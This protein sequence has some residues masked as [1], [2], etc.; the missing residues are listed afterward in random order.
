MDIIESK[1]YKPL[2][3]KLKKK[4]PENICSIFFYNKGV[5]CILGDPEISSALPTFIEFPIHMVT[6]KLGL[7]LSTKIFNFKH[8]VN[9]F[10]RAY[11]FIIN[12]KIRSLFFYLFCKYIRFG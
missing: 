3:L 6:Y 5:A 2:P 8:F 10:V 1:L 11:N 12:R 9:M 4:Q 7:P